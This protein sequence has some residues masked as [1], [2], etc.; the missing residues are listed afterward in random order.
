MDEALRTEGSR[1]LGSHLKFHLLTHHLNVETIDERQLNDLYRKR[2]P[3]E[4]VAYNRREKQTLMEGNDRLV[5]GNQHLELFLKVIQEKDDH[6]MRNLRLQFKEEVLITKRV[7]GPKLNHLVELVIVLGRQDQK[8][9]PKKIPGHG[10]VWEMA[11][12]I[13]ELPNLETFILRH[14]TVDTTFDLLKA[15]GGVQWPKVKQI[16]LYRVPT[17]EDVLVSF[18]NKFHGTLKSLT[19]QNPIMRPSTMQRL[20]QEIFR[21]DTNFSFLRRADCEISD[22]FVPKTLHILF[23]GSKED[24]DDIRRI[25]GEVWEQTKERLLLRWDDSL[26]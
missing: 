1:G 19:I 6:K 26:M 11:P 23:E 2:N 20:S 14:T 4:S 24:F 3:K 15:L 21:M 22:V 13:K 8:R 16:K 12:W 10:L 17:T 18:L 7:S 9:Q 25:G 5:V